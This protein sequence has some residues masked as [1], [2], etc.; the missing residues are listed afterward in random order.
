MHS[1][2][3]HQ[4]GQLGAQRRQNTFAVVIGH[5][6]LRMPLTMLVELRHKRHDDVARVHA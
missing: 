2:R 4:R 3:T 5:V 6:A 1:G